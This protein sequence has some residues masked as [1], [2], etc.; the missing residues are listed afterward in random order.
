MRSPLR[1]R[2]ASTARDP[3][4]RRLPFPV[5][6]V[7]LVAERRLLDGRLLTV[8]PGLR[9][10]GR[11]LAAD[12]RQLLLEVLGLALPVVCGAEVGPRRGEDVFVQ[13]AGEPGG[14]M[15]NPQGAQRLDQRKGREVEV[16]ELDV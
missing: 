15:N 13:A 11:D 9:L 14:L 5:P 2:D 4:R 12:H 7:V 16:A 6:E 8:E 3:R 10:L 1:R